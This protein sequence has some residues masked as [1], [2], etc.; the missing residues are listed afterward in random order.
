MAIGFIHI[1]GRVHHLAANKRR[2][3]MIFIKQKLVHI[4]L[5]V[6][7]LAPAFMPA[8][9]A[10]TVQA[11]AHSDQQYTAALSINTAD[12]PPIVLD[13]NGGGSQSGCGGG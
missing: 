5:L 3:L 8:I 7:L 12:T 13:C 11:I 2:N 6:L 4:Y 9:G 10:R 1:F